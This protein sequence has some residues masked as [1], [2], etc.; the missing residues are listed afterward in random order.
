M[1]KG[2]LGGAQVGVGR[3]TRCHCC[4]VGATTR[5]AAAAT[6]ADTSVG[7]VWGLLG[8]EIV[9]YGVRNEAA[10]NLSVDRHS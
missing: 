8:R 10:E 4:C 2:Q 9:G 6:A 3:G 1:G 5:A 7:T